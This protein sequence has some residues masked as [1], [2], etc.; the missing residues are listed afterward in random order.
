M[1]VDEIG[2]IL[3]K[4]SAR[5]S[6]R[7]IE[8]Q[9]EQEGFGLSSVSNYF[10]NW[11]DTQQQQPQEPESFF[12]GMFTLTR[13]Q[14]MYGFIMMIGLGLLCLFI[15]CLMLPYILFTA[16]KFAFM[17]TVGNLCLLCS[18]MFLQ[19]AQ[20]QL[21]TMF[22]Q[23]RWMPTSIWLVYMVLTFLCAIKIGNIVLTMM[24]IFIQVIAMAWYLLTFIPFGMRIVNM[25]YSTIR[26]FV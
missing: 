14:R 24:L 12:N 13:Q 8:S 16:R 18:T 23:E 9:V 25:F 15:A 19:G 7:D 6:G 22:N 17:Y 10:N 26:S 20:H 1:N 3:S 4:A 2:S 21:K 11:F 5:F